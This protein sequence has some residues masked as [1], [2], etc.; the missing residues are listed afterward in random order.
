MTACIDWD[1]RLQERLQKSDE[2]Y[3]ERKLGF[4]RKAR[5]SKSST[6]RVANSF[7]QFINKHT[8]SLRVLEVHSLVTRDV[9]QRKCGLAGAAER[10]LPTPRGVCAANACRFSHQLYEG[11]LLERS[12]LGVTVK[13]H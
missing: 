8:T 6:A 3:M 5:R 10:D 2:G 1:Y 11:W 7:E 12:L 9:Y 13:L 4:A